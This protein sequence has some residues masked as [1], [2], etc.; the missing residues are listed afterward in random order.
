[1]SVP[2][3]LS[4]C[5]INFITCI[6]P[7]NWYLAFISP[8]YLNI[9]KLFKPKNYLINYLTNVFF[10]HIIRKTLERLIYFLHY[11]SL[12][13]STGNFFHPAGSLRASV[14]RYS[15]I[16]H[17]SVTYVGILLPLYTCKI[18]YSNKKHNYV[19]MRLIYI[20]KKT[21]LFYKSTF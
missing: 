21:W 3:T 7:A 4:K 14:Y 1:M 16:V 8:L 6:I 15:V 13:E 9:F 10:S 18:H 19:Y 20:K 17:A 5:L 12:Q 2:I 11:P